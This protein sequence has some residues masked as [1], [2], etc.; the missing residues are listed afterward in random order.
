MA[1]LTSVN[2]QTVDAMSPGNTVEP[3]LTLLPTG[4]ARLERHSMHQLNSSTSSLLPSEPVVQRHSRKG[5]LG[6]G[7]QHG[8]SSSP[9]LQQHHQRKLSH[10]SRSLSQGKLDPY[11][12]TLS[13]LLPTS[14]GSL[15]PSSIS[16]AQHQPEFVMPVSPIATDP[17]GFS[18]ERQFIQQLQDG[19]SQ[20]LQALPRRPSNSTMPE[21]GRRRAHTKMYSTGQIDMFSHDPNFS[22]FQESSSPAGSL[23]VHSALPPHLSIRRASSGLA[24]HHQK[25]SPN[26]F[27][28]PPESFVNGPYAS[29]FSGQSFNAYQHSRNGSI[30]SVNS[31][32]NTPLNFPQDAPEDDAAMSKFFQLEQPSEEQQ[33]MEVQMSHIALVE[34]AS[35]LIK[36]EQPNLS[37]FDHH[38]QVRNEESDENEED[39]EPEDE[40]DPADL[41]CRWKG[42][43]QLFESQPTLV[44]HISE[45][46]IGSGKSS[47]LCEWDGCQRTGLPFAKRHK[48]HNHVRTHT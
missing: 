13:S 25:S 4:P 32:A 38:M 46:H 30:C 29:P 8:G 1:V 45:C 42:C 22:L 39:E 17:N 41:R 35:S 7:Q 16:S 10:H 37:Q 48:I 11:R 40:L 47:Y 24:L 43:G 23:P 31:V 15:T 9:Y 12:A 6:Q 20:P 27:L 14:P 26:P 5:S 33:K 28:S 19:M 2:R 18:P 3:E 44:S 36:Q 21:I 34:D